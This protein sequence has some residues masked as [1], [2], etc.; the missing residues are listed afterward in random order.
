MRA[1]L[2]A[3]TAASVLA[4]AGCGATGAA[5]MREGQSVP[6]GDPIVAAAGDIACPSDLPTPSACQQQATSDLLMTPLSAVLPLGDLQ[7]EQGR[8]ENF[9]RSYDPTWGRV[10]SITHP[11]PGDHDYG[12]SVDASGYFTYFGRLA[13]PPGKGYYSFNLGSWHIVALNGICENVGGCGQGSVQERWLAHDLAATPT[14][15]VLAYWHQPRFSSGRERNHPIY[16]AFWRDLYAAGAEMV[17]NGDEHHYERFDPQRPDARLDTMQGIRELIV[18]TGGKN[19]EP[20]GNTAANSAVRDS[21]TFGVLMITLHGD[22]Y[23]WRFVPVAGRTF[24]D[25]GRGTCH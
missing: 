21:D 8:L 18:G 16:D 20:F 14:K 3:L 22:G 5:P 6:Q 24:S 9:R 17:L 15:C 12:S 25:R 7:Y 13:G 23:D 19:H 11:V 10:K 1:G 4:L 2:S